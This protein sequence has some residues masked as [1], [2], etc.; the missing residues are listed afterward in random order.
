MRL[1][2]ILLALTTLSAPAHA[3]SRYVSTSM[4]CGEAQ[5]RV[6]REGE[7]V[8]RWT[9]ARNPGLPLY[10]RY[11]ADRSFCQPTE[12]LYYEYI[13]TSDTDQC[14]VVTCKEILYDD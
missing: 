7:V 12:A 1:L 13:P 9:S 2:A 10:N 6:L 3:T 8:L 11:V 14:P 4:T 5:D